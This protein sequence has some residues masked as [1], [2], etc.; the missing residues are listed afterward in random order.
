MKTAGPVIVISALLLLAATCHAQQDRRRF[1]VAA[2]V[3]HFDFVGVQRDG[4]LLYDTETLEGC[5][6]VLDHVEETG[7]TTILWRN[8]AGGTMRY[9]SAIETGHHPEILDKRRLC[10]NR[11]LFGWV[12]Y[13]QTEPDIVRE[14]MVECEERGLFA[15]VHWPFEETH[16]AVWTIGQFN[17][18][19]P[20]LW[21]R[22]AD[23][24][25]WWGR[26][27]LAW[28]EAAEQKL[29]LVDELIERGMDRLFIDFYRSGGWGPGQE[30]VPPVVEDWRERHGEAP[31][32]GVTDAWAAH[33]AEYVTAYMRRLRQRLDASG[34]DIDLMVGIPYIA[35]D[36]EWPLRARAAD[37]RT[38]GEEGLIDTL[39]INFVRWDEDR[40]FE[41]TREIGREIMDVV[42]GRC[43][44][45]WPVRAYDYGGFGM[46]SY[47][48][49][50]ELSQEEIAE[51]LMVMAWEEGADGVSLEC[52]D[53]QNYREP[54]RRRMAELADGPCRW[55][56]RER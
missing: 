16:G 2:W 49:A 48:E 9:Q 18:E 51:R 17:M 24:R 52:V 42:D 31:P 8:C 5:R 28:D 21:A 11:P 13:R 26:C 6:D 55:V 56:R 7:A 27:S 1:E 4:E 40:P 46:P 14:M 12:R 35:A 25:P 29:A 53:Y 20:Q 15:G 19:H 22:A 30:F 36:A 37:W 33:V 50:T 44:V 32:P 43:R 3:D 41:S 10:D 54:T 39:V 38:W 34:R 47:A 45:L 23:G